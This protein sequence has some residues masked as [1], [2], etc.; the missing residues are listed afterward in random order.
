MAHEMGVEEFF[1]GVKDLREMRKNDPEG[2][3]KWCNDRGL[4]EDSEPLVFTADPD[5]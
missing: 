2:Y 5:E 1:R 3:Q 4:T